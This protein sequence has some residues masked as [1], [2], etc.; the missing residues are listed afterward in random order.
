MKFSVFCELDFE[1]VFYKFG[2][3]GSCQFQRHI[4]IQFWNH[5]F[6]RLLE[7]SLNLH[8]KMQMFW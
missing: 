1:E 8:F 3:R 7:V 6:L 5:F 2:V 4:D